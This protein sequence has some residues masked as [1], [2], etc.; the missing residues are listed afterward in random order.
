MSDNHI[1]LL[2]AR[3]IVGAI[4]QDLAKAWHRFQATVEAAHTNVKALHAHADIRKR[5]KC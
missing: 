2:P 1:N 3:L 4:L 5:L